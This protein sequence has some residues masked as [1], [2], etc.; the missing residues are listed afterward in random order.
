MLFA[1][2][3][4]LDVAQCVVCSQVAVAFSSKGCWRQ[5]LLC[6]GE[7]V[8][9]SLGGPPVACLRTT[10]QQG[11]GFPYS[12][13]DAEA[14]VQ[15][16]VGRLRDL[17]P[18]CRCRCFPMCVG[19][20]SLSGSRGISISGGHARFKGGGGCPGVYTRTHAA[21][22][23]CQVG[24]DSAIKRMND[25]TIKW[26]CTKHPRFMPITGMLQAAARGQGQQD[27]L[28]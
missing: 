11:G 28:R 18:H 25:R 5:S 20:G 4:V 8:G 12:R 3:F 17:H 10:E 15:T 26:L 21:R 7:D 22:W 13:F 19:E 14:H 2:S 6:L 27:Q 24:A 1:L 23:N 9:G 16:Q